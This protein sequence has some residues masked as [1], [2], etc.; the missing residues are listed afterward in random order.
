[1]VNLTAALSGGTGAS[2]PHHV[3]MCRHAKHVGPAS[4]YYRWQGTAVIPLP[5]VCPP[6]VAGS[7]G[8]ADPPHWRRIDQA[9][10]PRPPLGGKTPKVALPPMWRTKARELRHQVFRQGRK[11]KVAEF[12]FF[13]GP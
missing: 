9:D 11:N 13:N 5:P 4:A 10:P 6:L 8:P 3:V 7:G 2:R 1:M 12:V